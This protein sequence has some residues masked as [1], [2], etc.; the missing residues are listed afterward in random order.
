MSSIN[1]AVNIL[2][3]DYLTYSKILGMMTVFSD[4]KMEKIVLSLIKMRPDGYN[5]STE[6]TNNEYEI[7][8]KFVNSALENLLLERIIEGVVGCRLN[9]LGEIEYY[10]L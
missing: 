10:S 6:L 2:P 9:D 1:N 4:E 3:K 5:D 7:I 8:S